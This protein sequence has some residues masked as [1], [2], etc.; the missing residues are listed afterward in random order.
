[1]LET[2][3]I[4]NKRFDIKNEFLLNLSESS[5]ITLV[6]NDEK[7]KIRYELCNGDYNILVFNNTNNGVN[8]IEEGYIK[9][10]KVNITYIDLNDNKY[11]QVNNL[12]VYKDSSL[13]INCIYLGINE[14]NIK[15]NVTNVESDSLV[16]IINNVVCLNNCDF[17]LDIIGN[18]KNGAKRSKCFQ[19]SSCLTF[20]EPRKAKVLPVLNIDENDV[21]AS[22]SL[23][24]GTIDEE[25]L[26]YMNSRGLTKK[27]ALSLLLTSYLMPDEDF[28]KTFEDG[29][30]LKDI[31]EKKVEKLCSI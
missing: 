25:V 23:S 11:N 10:S 12:E 19:K 30:L 28:Y 16:N 18:I 26:F 3:E 21:E 27:E 7:I 2:L 24:C 17:T 31:A 8:L 15:Y 4:M 6:L 1:M 13:Y 20:E 14:K 5:S 22:H 29:L 9:N